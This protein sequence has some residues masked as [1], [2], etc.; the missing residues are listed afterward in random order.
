[1]GPVCEEGK[2]RTL[3]PDY[4]NHTGPNQVTTVARWREDTLQG[5]SAGGISHMEGK[6]NLCFKWHS[7]DF[8]VYTALVKSSELYMK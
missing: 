7:I 6:Y 4:G 5:L 3:N 8:I 1:M 2:T